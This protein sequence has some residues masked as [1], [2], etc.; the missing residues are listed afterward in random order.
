M[1]TDVLKST[2]MVDVAFI[3]VNYNTKALLEDLVA[4]FTAARL[5]FSWSLTVVDN[6]SS[7]GSLE[8]LATCPDLQ[9]VRN[10]ENI[11][12]GRAMNRGIAATSSRYLCLLNTDVI[13]NR[14]ALCALVN[15]CDS[16]E[17]VQVCSPVVC[18]EDGRMQG[19]FMHFSLSNLYFELFKKLKHSRFKRTIAATQAPLQVDGIAGAFIFCR[20]TLAP[21]GILFDEDF[22]FYYEDTELAWRLWQQGARCEV[23]TAHRIVHLGGKSSSIRHIRLFYTSKYLFIRKTYG[24]G[25]ERTIRS[26]DAVRITLKRNFYRLLLIM[27]DSEKLRSKYDSYNFADQVLKEIRHAD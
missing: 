20:R 23:L 3:T 7:D 6:A 21:R 14:E 15:H 16:H 2:K 19:F 17:E 5:P 8:F 18:Y 1:T 26:L 27:T 25:H 12:Y 4:F 11:G 13:L 24:T 10:H 22:F 9:V